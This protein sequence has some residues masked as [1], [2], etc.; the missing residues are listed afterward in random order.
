MEVSADSNS[1]CFY[2]PIVVMVH[3]A[4]VLLGL[5]NTVCNNYFEGANDEG[6]AAGDASPPF[7]IFF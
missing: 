2:S 5:L 1:L 3:G 7:T 6:I 4:S